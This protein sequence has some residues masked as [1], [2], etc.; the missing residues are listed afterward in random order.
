M[1]CAA[2]DEVLR[3]HS[4]LR[5][6]TRRVCFLLKAFKDGYQVVSVMDDGRAVTKGVHVLVC[7]AWHGPAP[8]SGMEVAH[9]DGMRF[10]NAPGNV[11]WKTKKQNGADRVRHGTTRRGE[12]N[13]GARINEM[14]ARVIFH[15]RNLPSGIRPSAAEIGR[16]F[17]ISDVAVLFIWKR[18]TWRYVT[19]DIATNDFVAWSTRTVEETKLILDRGIG[20]AKVAR[21]LDLSERWIAKLRRRNR[22]AANNNKTEEVND[23]AAHQNQ[24]RVDGDCD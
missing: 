23:V 24:L 19:K 6:R 21:M 2:R 15:M 12:M 7:T 22:T 10:N 17:G 9:E 4:L 13:I 8:A 20:A 14:T 18:R 3:T 5:N 11:N 16:L 1:I